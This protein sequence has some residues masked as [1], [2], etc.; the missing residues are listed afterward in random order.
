MKMRSIILILTSTPSNTSMSTLNAGSGIRTSVTQGNDEDYM[1]FGLDGIMAATK[2][3][4]GVSR[5]QVPEDERDSYAFKTFLTPDKLLRERI[6]LDADK[7]RLGVLRK[8]AR[9]RSLKAVPP[10]CFDGYGKGLLIG[11]PLA[12]PLEETN[13]MH[14]VEQ[15]RRMSAFG[16]GGIGSK[17]AITDAS[18]AINP[19]SFG[20]VS[21]IRA[22]R[23]GILGLD[24]RLAEG[25]HFGSDGNLYRVMKNRRTGKN[26]WVSQHQAAKRRDRNSSLTVNKVYTLVRVCYS[27]NLH[28]RFSVTVA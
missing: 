6:R 7:T 18:V 13:P 21:P 12:S 1:P 20:Y 10:A 14:I 2:K 25:V 9:T 17:D 5:G 15:S 3:L 11:N 8:A 28:W 26:E 4:K 22:S 16:P 24:C 19:S 27:N 23:G